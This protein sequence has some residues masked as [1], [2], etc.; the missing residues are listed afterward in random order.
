MNFSEP[1]LGEEYAPNEPMLDACQ[2][3]KWLTHW[4]E[5]AQ[6]RIKQKRTVDQEMLDLRIEVGLIDAVLKLVNDE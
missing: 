6:K 1:I 2:D 4:R 5:L 3:P